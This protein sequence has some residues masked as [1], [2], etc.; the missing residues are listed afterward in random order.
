MCPAT[1]FKE[2]ATELEELRELKAD[3][4]RR[5]RAQAAVIENQAKRL[6]ELEVLYKVRRREPRCGPLR[7]MR[8]SWRRAG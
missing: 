5:E 8:D 3:V 4:E 6:E 1:Q 2:E 7:P